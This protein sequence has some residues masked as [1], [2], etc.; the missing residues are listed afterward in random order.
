MIHQLVNNLVIIS[1]IKK[2]HKNEVSDKLLIKNSNMQIRSTSSLFPFSSFL[3]T[4]MRKRKKCDHVGWLPSSFEWYWWNIK[5]C[6]QTDHPMDQKTNWHTNRWRDWPSY[7]DA[8]VHLKNIWPQN[9]P[10]KYY[11]T[12][13]YNKKE[14]IF[15]CNFLTIL[16]RK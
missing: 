13:Q 7:K 4:R 10:Q 12:S 1:W 8:W 11:G 14:V 3:K 5:K 9:N 2:R 15:Y 6:L 16:A